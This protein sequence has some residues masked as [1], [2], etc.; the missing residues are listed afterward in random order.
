MVSV[1]EAKTV[2]R[3][4]WLAHRS[5]YRPG[6]CTDCAGSRT[7]LCTEAVRLGRAMRDEMTAGNNNGYPA[8]SLPGW[9][10]ELLNGAE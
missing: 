10:T 3:R 4:A 2:L 8:E 7:H 5:I 9:L 1:N 6:H